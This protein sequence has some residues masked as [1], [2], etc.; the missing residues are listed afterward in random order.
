MKILML[1]VAAKLSDPDRGELDIAIGESEQLPGCV[2]ISFAHPVSW[3]GMPVAKARSLAGMILDSVAR[4]ETPP[5]ELAE[6][7]AID[8]AQAEPNPY[9]A[10]LR[11]EASARVF[12]TTRLRLAFEASEELLAKANVRIDDLDRQLA[13]ERELY[14]AAV[15]GNARLIAELVRLSEVVGE[16]DAASIHR[17][18]A[19]E[20]IIEALTNLGKDDA[21]KAE[22]TEG[23]PKARDRVR[24]P[25]GW[26]SRESRKKEDG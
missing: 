16:Q 20:R 22:E 9:A 3:F 18:L 19:G 26:S 4:V 15:D 12:E 10:R 1:D 17:A 2:V 21:E 11:R 13:E 6:M 23:P 7:P 5:S 14:L 24:H 8:F 25:P